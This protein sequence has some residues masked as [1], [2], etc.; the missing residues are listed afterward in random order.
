MHNRLKGAVA[1]ICWYALKFWMGPMLYG[2]SSDFRLAHAGWPRTPA[3][4]N[5]V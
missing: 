4:I 1:M 2:I 5:A 3:F